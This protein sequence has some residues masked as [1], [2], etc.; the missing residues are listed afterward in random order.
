MSPLNKTEG[1]APSAESK[2]FAATLRAWRLAR[3]LTQDQLAEQANVSKS[4]ISM[5]ER[6]FHSMP[7]KEIT[8][9]KLAAALGI[10]LSD[11][12]NMPSGF[13]SPVGRD[14]IA[15]K[16]VIVIKPSAH[17]AREMSD[18]I[19][20]SKW[21][22]GASYNPEDLAYFM[23]NDSSMQPTLKVGD[24]AIVESFVTAS[25]GLYL[26]GICSD[27]TICQAGI[28]RVTPTLT[29]KVRVSCDN[30]R[31]DRTT[32]Q[33]SGENSIIGRVILVIKASEPE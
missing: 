17:N 20:P 26:V 8:Q 6:A 19:L 27:N 7:P 12:R 25:P 4:S 14:G 32:T 29:G 28:R 13:G 21:I 1:V 30:E 24:I 22:L 18:L 9:S 10:T 5:A 11:L 15:Q 3:G 16:G 2:A 23:V 33:P 31:F